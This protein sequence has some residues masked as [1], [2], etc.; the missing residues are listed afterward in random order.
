VWEF[1]RL[2]G[3]AEASHPILWLS[4]T[5]DLVTPLGNAVRMAGRFP[6]SVVFGQDAD[7]HATLAQRSLC[8]GGD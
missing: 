7:G 4:N 2:I 8:Y 6:G 1:N 3:A 5:R